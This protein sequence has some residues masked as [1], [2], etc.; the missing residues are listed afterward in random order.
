[1][2]LETNF[3]RK[4]IKFF[5][6][7]AIIFI[8]WHTASGQ[9]LQKK[10]TIRWQ[11]VQTIQGIDFKPVKALCADGLTNSPSRNFTPVFTKKFILPQDIN[12]CDVL[13]THTE[14]EP[15]DGQQLV[16]LSFPVQA[17]DTLSYSLEFGTERGKHVAFLQLLPVISDQSGGLLRLKSFMINLV[18]L[19]ADKNQSAAV[20][21]AYATHSLLA[22]GNWYKVQLSKTGIYKISYAEMQAMGINMATVNPA[23]IRLFGY[24]G[25]MLSEANSVFRHDDLFENAISVVTANQGVFAPGDYILFYGTS[26]DK[27]VYNKT[28]KKFEHQKNLYSDV[29]CYFLNFESGPGLRIDDQ[30]QSTQTPT[31]TCEGFFDC[32]FYE[33]DLTNF[34]N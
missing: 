7:L 23:N 27:I 21:T 6:A 14:W 3:M 22:Q 18:Y 31:Y 10:I 8:A 9:G 29:T 26:P 19:P 15:L 13:V 24:G 5:T 25:G 4:R 1:M 2:L 30:P 33:N 17:A 12:S 28:A 11:G 16:Q 20:K 34:I 32:V